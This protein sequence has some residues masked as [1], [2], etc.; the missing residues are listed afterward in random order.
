MAVLHLLSVHF[1]VERSF[2]YKHRMLLGHDPQLVE[3]GV[4]P[5]LL[6][7]VPVGDYTVLP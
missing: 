2:G 7:I 5:Y 1:G 6:H 4:V 3:E